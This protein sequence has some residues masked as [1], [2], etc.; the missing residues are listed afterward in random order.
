MIRAALLLAL[1]VTSACSGI[2]EIA[3]LEEPAE[4]ASH[5]ADGP[6]D[7][8]PGTC[9]GRDETPATLQTVTVESVVTPA[10]YDADGKLLKPAVTATETRQEIVEER[11]EL[12]F[13]TP[14]PDSFTPDT[15]ASLQRAL[16]A[17]GVYDGEITGSLDSATRS[18]IR[19]YQQPQGLNSAVLSLTAARQ[20]GLVAIAIPG[21]S[22]ER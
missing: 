6:P 10:S 13:E 11:Q 3:R 2:P 4:I 9:W 5:G 8:A 22:S 7:A 21:S 19:R 20:L 1:L 15:V 18:A 16:K 12:W 14:C 17:R